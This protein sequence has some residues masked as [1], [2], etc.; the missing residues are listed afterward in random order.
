MD[1]GTFPALLKT[2]SDSS[3]E[4]CTVFQTTSGFNCNH[5]FYRSSNTTCNCWLK[6]HQARKK[7]ISKLSWWTCWSSSVPIGAF[8]KLE[9]ALLFASCVWTL[10]QRRYTVP[11]Q[12]SLRKKTQVLITIPLLRLINRLFQDLEFASVIV[13]K[14]NIILIT[15]PELADFRK[16]LKSVETRVSHFIS[17]TFFPIPYDYEIYSKTDKRCSRHFTDHGATTQ[18]QFSLC[19]SW[20]KPMNTLQISYISCRSF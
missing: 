20:P 8:W 10:T 2:L 13:Q 11:S 1:D 17:S 14:L 16:R 19:A 18:C 9:E 15:S 6:F 5:Q 4:V 7:P 3:E 12:R